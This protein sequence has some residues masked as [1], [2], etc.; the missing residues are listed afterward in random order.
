MRDPITSKRQM[1]DPLSRGMLGN[2]IRQFFSV[3]EWRAS[4]EAELYPA[5]GVRTLAPGGPC[6]LYCPTA[7]VEATA[8]LPEYRAAGVN[9]SMMVDSVRRNTLMAD[10]FMGTHGLELYGIVNP[11][12]GT[13]WRK[14]MPSMGRTYRFT[15]VRCILES[16]L[17]PSDREDLSELLEMYPGHVV[18]FSAYDRPVG[19]YPHRKAVVWEVRI[20]DGSYERPVWRQDAAPRYQRG[21]SKEGD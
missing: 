12:P 17:T 20:D 15:A 4:G 14:D 7:E 18:E 19:I 13:N 3:E 8:S 9:I 6:R 21:W 2:T 10:L 16:V 1:Y 11:P 5:W